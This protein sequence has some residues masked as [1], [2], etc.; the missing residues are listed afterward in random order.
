VSAGADSRCDD[1]PVSASAQRDALDHVLVLIPD[2]CAAQ[3]LREAA[4]NR[5]NFVL[6]QSL[7]QSSA[8]VSPLPPKAARHAVAQ[9]LAELQRRTGIDVS[10][11]EK[12]TDELR[13]VATVSV[14]PSL[15]VGT[16]LPSDLLDRL[17]EVRA[18]NTAWRESVSLQPLTIHEVQTEAMQVYGR[19]GIEHALVWTLEE[20]GELAQAIRR[21]EHETRIEEELGQ[22]AAWV[23]CLGNIC[24]VSVTDA[25]EASMR[26]EVV[27]Q[28][29]KYGH[30]KPANV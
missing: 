29:R 5:P 9:A 11:V 14:P 4:T 20:L 19:V 22:L 24:G 2:L 27:R 8:E 12:L 7:D 13:G 15:M 6:V 26:D 16:E 25:L 30:R 23:F 10:V 17:E 18:E 21:G 1:E 3:G 28:M